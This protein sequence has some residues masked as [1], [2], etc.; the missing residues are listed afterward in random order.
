MFY[1]DD[2][3]QLTEDRELSKEKWPEVLN[4]LLPS[5]FD[6]DPLKWEVLGELR[7][8]QKNGKA[9]YVCIFNL[10]SSGLGAFKAGEDKEWR[11]RRYFRGGNSSRQKA[12]LRKAVGHTP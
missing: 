8:T 7:I 1:D 2:T 12:A 6:P 11:S 3:G 9:I 5:E 10:D 4:A